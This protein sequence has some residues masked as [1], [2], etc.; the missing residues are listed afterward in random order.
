MGATVTDPLVGRLVDGRYEVVS[1]IARG[2]MATVY[3]AVDRR[4]D[5][6]VALKV[7][8]P[9]LAEGASGSDFVARF[10][11][12]ARAAARLTHPG[13]VG[14]YDQGVDG[15][16]SYLTMEHVDGSN[17]RRRLGE[18]GALTVEEALRVGES[19]LD[20]LAA[21]H[22]AGLVHRDIKPE[23]VLLATDGRVKLADFGLARAVTEV[24]STTTGT[25]LGTVA[26]LAPEL[27]VRGASD[28]RTDVYACGILL[29]EML[30]G[31]QPFTGETPIQVAFQHV[32]SDV[33][34]PSDELTWL[35]MEVDELVQALAARA[36]D[37]RPVDAAAALVL[38]R[39]T[40]AA[41]DPETLARRADVAPSIVLPLATDPDETD[42]DDL[43][44]GTTPTTADEDGQETTRLDA[45]SARGA[46]VALP[47]G[48]GVQPADAPPDRPA[49]TDARRHRARW[50]VVL[51][52]LA[53][54]VG[55]GVLWYVQ[56]GP[57]AFTTVPRVLGGDEATVTAALEDAGLGAHATH[58]FDTAAPVDTVFATEPGVGSRVRKGTVVVFT[59]SKGPD[60]VQ[61]PDGVVLVLQKDAANA[62]TTA[63]LTPR[64]DEPK[65]DDTAA[66]GYVLSA[67]LPDG[68]P[69]A[70]GTQSTR[71]TEVTLVV[72]KGPAPAA[73]TSVVGDTVEQATASLLTDN[74]K[75]V[76]TEA[77]HDTVE[78]GRIISQDPP[79]GTQ[80][81]RGDTVDVV[82]SKGPE[83]IAL[84]N[85][86]GQ[87][88]KTA[89]KALEDLGFVVKVQHPQGI[90]PLNLV[91][92]QSPAG[93][94][95]KTAPKGSTITLNV[96]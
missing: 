16:T 63:G 24:T 90:S 40:R 39:R 26:Y 70:P 68:T 25:V 73:I 71:G 33:P 79:S 77:F 96:F 6:D 8:H 62:L 55:A 64:Y 18:R 53:A 29:F 89:Q 78:A 59:V 12:E 72:S 36:P 3:L 37:D 23:N 31:R 45:S 80:G 93:G 34:A 44:E 76:A 88:V 57:G 50:W 13:L 69:A 75:L 5:R 61:V 85:T 4:L 54:L 21:A 91:Y 15:E 52:V 30:T 94:E 74:M 67:T 56:A 1:R 10:R 11:R 20:A 87:N 58:D 14:V 66:N 46:T 42:L 48:L 84:P 92:S 95:G 27:V 65:Y 81:H 19:V 17:L 9:H 35:P 28:A 51:A 47:I 7:M 43:D 38:L 49:P 41:L 32:N 86:Y 2:G 82:V 60:Y 83:P 22:R